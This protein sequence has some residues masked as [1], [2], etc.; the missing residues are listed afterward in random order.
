MTGHFLQSVAASRTQARAGT[1]PRCP[2]TPGRGRPGSTGPPASSCARARASET[3]ARWRL[4]SR[5][6]PDR[7]GPPRP[8]WSSQ[9]QRPTPSRGDLLDRLLRQ[10]LRDVVARVAAVL[11]LVWELARTRPAIERSNHSATATGPAHAVLLQRLRKPG[12]QDHLAYG[13]LRQLRDSH[14]RPLVQGP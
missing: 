12:A 5:D 8:S 4:R 9:S 14:L 1:C 6:V 10:P 3:N 13:L 11:V 7:L 2:S